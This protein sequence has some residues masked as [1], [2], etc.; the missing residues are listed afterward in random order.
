MK[1]ML[2][3]PPWSYSE[4]R[5][6]GSERPARLKSFWDVSGQGVLPPYGL[7]QLASV[8]RET[9]HEVCFFDGYL[10]TDSEVIEYALKENPELIG[11]STPT[12]L[13]EKT[14][15]ILKRLRKELPGVFFLLGGAHSTFAKEECLREVPELDAAVVGEGDLVI[16]EIA[17]RISL[18][19]D[20]GGID[21]L[22]FRRG[23]EVVNNSSICYVRNL[24]ELPLPA[25]DLI[26]FQSY[27]PNIVFL[28]KTPFAHV[29]TARGCSQ[30]CSFCFYGKNTPVR[31]KNINYLMEEIEYLVK[32]HGVKTINFY[33]DNNIFAF[34]EERGYALCKRLRQMKKKPSWSIYLVNF[35]IGE[36][37][38]REMK[39]SGCF[40]IHCAVESGTQ[41]NR[42]R[43]CGHRFSIKK[44][45][46]KIRRIRKLGISTCGRFQLGIPGETFA[47]GLETIDFAC[48]LSLD[49]AF[50]VRAF[51]FP[52]S[53][54]FEDYRSMG[55]VNPDKR[56]WNSYVRFY[57]P[58]SMEQKDVERLIKLGYVRFY[59][60]PSWWIVKLMRFWEYGLYLK[61][62]RRAVVNQVI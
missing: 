39:Q 58:G 12:C 35:D 57:R 38:L 18:G 42:D 40:R 22:V 29:V 9:G 62:F 49:Y 37:I 60:R 4:L 54:M 41:K 21:G 8:L 50:F 31:F 7:L 15:F 33:D 19:Q 59:R 20:L 36:G 32:Q 44:I 56:K 2:L 23:K 16:R 14:K 52:G 34:D 55:R 43:I 26:N 53:L 28:H 17:S 46:E 6:F 13:W 10:K 24:N 11:I 1:T 45:A 47:E 3:T 30:G 61:Y 25:Y 51:L 5:N 48:R 27:I